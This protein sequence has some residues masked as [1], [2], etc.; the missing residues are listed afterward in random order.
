MN[1]KEKV[2]FIFY[3]FKSFCATFPEVYADIGKLHASLSPDFNQEQVF[4][5][6]EGAGASGSFFFFSHDK[7]FII[8]TLTGSELKLLLKI[9]ESLAKH[10]TE[11]KSSLLSKFYGVFTVESGKMGA[12]N[13]IMM[14]NT[15]DLDEPEQ[16]RYIFDLKGS[17]VSRL[18]KG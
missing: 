2:T 17:R 5:A 7:R 13:I 11:N 16:L 12:V 14:E 8:K 6:G 10:H 18:V 4:Q 1:L 15:L 3:R 9:Q